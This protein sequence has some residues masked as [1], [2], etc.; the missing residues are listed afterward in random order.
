MSD[1]PPPPATASDDAA[2][3]RD[4]AAFRKALLAGDAAGVRHS[5]ETSVLVRDRVNA[6][7]YDFG[8]RAAHLAA[9]HIPVLDVLLE[10]GAD[11]MLRSDWDKGPYTVLDN[12]TE[13]SARHLIS[14][15]A[16][17]TPNVASRLGWFEELRRLVEHNPDAV[18]ARGGD[19][20][21]PLHEAAT[22]AIADYLLDRGAGIDVPCFD[23]QSTPAQYALADRPEVCRRLL[24]RGAMPDIY[25]AA[26]LG[27]AAL[28]DRLIAE[29]PSV[30]ATRVDRAGYAPVPPFNIYCWT[31]GRAL[32]PHAVALEFDQPAMYDLLLRHSPPHVVLLDAASRGDEASVTRLVRSDPDVIAKLSPGDHAEL[33]LAIFHERFD[34]AF[35]MLQHGF[36]PAAGG[37]DGGTALHAA[38]WVGHAGLVDAIVRLGTIPIETRDPS[39]DST[40]LGWASFG[41]VYRRAKQGDYVAVVDRLIAAGADVHAPGNV[42]KLS[43]LRMAEGNGAVQAALRR[44]GAV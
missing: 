37:V 31:L 24:Q 19:G 33:A 28:A 21:Q 23:H 3:K 22:V 4:L 32:S 5:L 12:A 2:L 10:F 16:E 36:D 35:V 41:S 27:D 25:M 42:H 15:G 38:C 8:Q 1:P 7:L 34:A 26:R 6:P 44:H 39:H 40:P 13:E 30:L 17:L 14:R 20:K 29:D 18:H 9:K 11:F 43:Y